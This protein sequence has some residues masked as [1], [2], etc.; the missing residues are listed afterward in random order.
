MMNIE[1]TKVEI[2][3][4]I[5]ADCYSP[6]SDPPANLTWYINDEQV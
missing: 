2:G 1:Q 5:K 4:K 3:K 6:G